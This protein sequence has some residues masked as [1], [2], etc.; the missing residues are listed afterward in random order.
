MER[1]HWSGILLFCAA[2]ALG[3]S[4]TA[5]A[6]SCVP[7]CREGFT[8]VDGE[9]VSACNPPCNEGE[10]CSGDGFCI[11][12]TSPAAAAAAS[13]GGNPGLRDAN[14]LHV[15]FRIGAGGVVE[16]FN[17][18]G[19]TDDALA[20]VGLTIR[21]EAPV[22]EVLTTGVLWS[23]YS[24]GGVNS[25]DR[26]LGMDLSPFLK[27]RYAFAMGNKK[28]EGEVYG[29]FQFGLSLAYVPDNQLID[30]SD[31][32]VGFNT[33]LTPGFM[34]WPS[35]KVGTFFEVGYGYAWGRFDGELTGT[36]GQAVIRFGVAVAF[37]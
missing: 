27:G 15:I 10:R 20:T 24:F 5:Q 18:V 29:L 28:I 17:G 6:Q 11:A 34:V 3:A 7:D 37:Y 14:R 31:F 26:S 19:T 2:V 22:H 25:V 1:G 16:R 13:S 12:D 32:G 9:C 8:C 4:T 35:D 36:L 21:F 30:Y 33:A 23:L